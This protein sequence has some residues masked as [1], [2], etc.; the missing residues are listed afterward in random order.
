MEHGVLN[1]SIPKM[2]EEDVKKSMK[3]IEIC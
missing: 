1:V 2:N 3:V